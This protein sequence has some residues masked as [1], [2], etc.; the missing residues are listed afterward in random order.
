MKSK[1][2]FVWSSSD[3]KNFILSDESAGIGL[4]KEVSY[5]NK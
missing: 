3:K 4:L 5:A 2:N 1:A